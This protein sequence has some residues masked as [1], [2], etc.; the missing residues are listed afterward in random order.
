MIGNANI[1]QTRLFN[2]IY[3]VWTTHRRKKKTEQRINMVFHQRHFIAREK[4]IILMKINLLFFFSPLQLNNKKLN[5][6]GNDRR[7]FKSKLEI[8]LEDCERGRI[9]FVQWLE[10]FQTNFYSNFEL[11]SVSRFFNGFVRCHL[12]W[13]WISIQKS[14]ELIKSIMN[15]NLGIASQWV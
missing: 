3:L 7:F 14:F 2:I 6:D 8:C 15:M 10:T 9:K 5:A 1:L 11:I 4:Q 13:I 12:I